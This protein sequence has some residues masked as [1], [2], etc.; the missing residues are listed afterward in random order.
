MNRENIESKYKWDLTPIFSS[1]D[2]FNNLYKDVE[3][4]IEKFKSHEKIMGNNAESFYNAI[5]DYYKISR[6]L[7]KLQVYTDLLSDIDTSNNNNQALKLKVI[8]LLDKWNKATFFITPTI[9]KK[10][11]KEI[12]NF[13]EEKPKLKEYETIIKREFRYKEHILSDIE[14]KLLSSMTKMFNKNY[15]TYE[16]LKDSDITFG[17]ITDENNKEVELTCS[18]YSIYIESNNRRVRKEAFATL[19]STYKQFINTFASTLSGN[20]NENVTIAKIKKFPSTLN[21]CLYADELDETIYNNLINTVSDNMNT[22]YKYYAL[23]KDLLN[24][25]ELHLYDIYTPIVKNFD[26]KYPY[27]EAKEIVL[28]ALSVLGDDYI[29]VL[30]NGLDNNWVDVYPTKAKRT[31]GYSGGCYDTAPYILLNYFDKYNDMST[32]AHEAGHSMHSYYTRSNNSY[33]YGNYSIFVAEVASTVNEILL[34]KYLLKTSNSKEEKLF[35]LDNLMSLFKAT[36]YRQTMFAEFEQKIYFDAENDI[37]LTADYLSSVYYELNKK[38]FGDD[39]VIDDDIKYEWAR[40]PHFYYNF[41]VYKY[42]TGLSAA[43]HIVTGILSGKEGAVEDYINFLKCGRTKSPI[44]SLK[45]AGVD[46]SKKE[47]V[48]SSIKMFK[49]T[50]DEFKEIYNRVYNKDI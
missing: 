23:K 14:E 8:N 47:T 39:V 43:C 38:Y 21:W 25:E 17:N 34:S 15:E 9:L 28:K 44:D 20:I 3:S 40:I 33:Q 49:D 1:E 6:D 41:Y 32:L 12:E 13:Y 4:K 48:T 46:L 18:N 27:E 29:E 37:P 30:K 45:V 5:N 42:A 31:G 26:K 11:Y 35:I 16:L 2:D 36:I 10:D 19:Y 22:L 50:I 24:L 7:D